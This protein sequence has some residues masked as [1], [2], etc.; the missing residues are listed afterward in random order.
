VRGMGYFWG[1]GLKTRWADGTPVKGEE[2]RR[3]F[4][5]FLGRRLLERGLICRVDDKE[6]MVIQLAPALVADREVLSSI[7]EIT[8]AAISDLE[9]EIGH[10]GA[11]E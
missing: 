11:R 8:D 1:M 6:E 2:Y 10:R 7:A 3:H 5:G 4:K 9:H